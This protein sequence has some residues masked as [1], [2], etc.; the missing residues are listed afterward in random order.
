MGRDIFFAVG[1]EY[2]G[3]LLHALTFVYV[4][5]AAHPSCAEAKVKLGPNVL[6]SITRTQ[7]YPWST[8]PEDST[9]QF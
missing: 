3:N 8:N 9:L 7:T 1:V 4:F 6:Q 2:V 5:S